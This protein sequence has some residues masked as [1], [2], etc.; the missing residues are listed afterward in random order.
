MIQNPPAIAGDMGSIPRLGRC[1]EEGF[2][3]HSS[4]LPGK[5]CVQ[6]SLVG[7]GPGLQKSQ[8]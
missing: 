8:I 4:I 7:Y 3:N 2:G 1:S 5:S 6:R